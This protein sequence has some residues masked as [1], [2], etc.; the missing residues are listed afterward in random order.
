MQE[1][2]GSIEKAHHVVIDVHSFR[3]AIPSSWVRLDYAFLNSYYGAQTFEDWS[4][5]SMARLVSR[6]PSKQVHLAVDQPR[7][8]DGR[9]LTFTEGHLT[10]SRSFYTLRQTV[11][12]D[13][14]LIPRDHRS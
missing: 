1:M 8:T 12:A 9:L 13:P 3:E 6:D 10:G 14:A 4:L 7:F 2:R 5:E 11:P